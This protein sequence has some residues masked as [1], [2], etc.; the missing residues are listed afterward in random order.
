ME[1]YLRGARLREDVDERASEEGSG[2]RDQ[3]SDEGR[4][5]NNNESL[6]RKGDHVLARRKASRQE[7]EGQ[8]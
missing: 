6:R 7:G 5:R 2:R 1:G 3:G 4:P 8:K